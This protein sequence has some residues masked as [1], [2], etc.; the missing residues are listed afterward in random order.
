MHEVG[1]RGWTK[2]WLYTKFKSFG[3]PKSYI[4]LLFTATAHH[5]VTIR[6]V[7]IK[8]TT[9]LIRIATVLIDNKDGRNA[10]CYRPHCDYDRLHSRR[11]PL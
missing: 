11:Q 4:Y 10:N 6:T 1:N 9:V 8:I 5:F 3:K 2:K 7:T